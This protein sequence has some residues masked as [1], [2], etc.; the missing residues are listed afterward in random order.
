MGFKIAIAG[1]T[2]NVGREMLNILSERGFPVSEVTPLPRAALSA[3]KCPSATRPSRSRTSK[4][5]ISPT[6]ISA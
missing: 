3:P 2:G 6:P 4:P 5:M 1:A